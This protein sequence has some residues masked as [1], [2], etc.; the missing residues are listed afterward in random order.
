MYFRVCG[1]YCA[2]SPSDLW[3]S[4]VQFRG[5]QPGITWPC[6]GLGNT[7][8]FVRVVATERNK[9]ISHCVDQGQHCKQWLKPLQNGDQEHLR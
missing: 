8:P 5:A 1:L 3:T 7:I 2:V 9:F 4:N 6:S